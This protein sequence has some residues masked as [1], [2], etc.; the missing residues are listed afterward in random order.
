[1]K[2]TRDV[3]VAEPGLFVVDLAAAD[4][5]TAFAMQNVIARRWATALAEHVT[6]QPGE[7]GARLRCYV[8]LRQETRCS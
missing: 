7:Q 1:M 8:D 2:P 5:D 3:H 4:D 6:R